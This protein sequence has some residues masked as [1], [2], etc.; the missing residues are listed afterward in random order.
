MWLVVEGLASEGRR[1]GLCGRR[2]RGPIVRLLLP[3][4]LL[5]RFR[6]RCRGVVGLLERRAVGC[7][8]RI[9]VGGCLVETW[10]FEF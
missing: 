5:L 2:S 7:Q 10:F 3:V 8:F 1:S 4:L 6:F 9:R